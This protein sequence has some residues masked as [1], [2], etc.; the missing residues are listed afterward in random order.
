MK[1]IGKETNIQALRKI[2]SLFQTTSL[3]VDELLAMV[4][5]TAKD[6]V[7]VKNGSLLLVQDEKTF[8]LQFYQAFGKNMGQ[9]KDIDLPPGVGISGHV[10]KTGETI[11]SNDVAKDPR[12]YQGVSEKM[13]I[14]VQSMAS[15]PLII[16]KKVI[17]VVQFLDKVDGTT[18][19]EKNVETLQSFA[20]LMAKFFQVSKSRKLL[21]EEFGRLK[22]QYLLRYT[23]VGESKAIQKCIAMAEKV[24][25]SKAS[26][27]LTGESGTGKELF[28]H[29]VH[30]RSQRQNKPFVSVSCGA[31]PASILERELFG[32]EKGAFT[33]ADSQKI[34]LFEA[35]NT[36]T[37]FLDEIGEMPLDM[38]VKLL[39]VIQEES[40]IRLGGTE[41]IKVDV[42]LITATNLDLD[43]E[44]Q[45]G[46]FRQDLFYRINVI[47]ITLP[48]L[49]EKLEDI[50]D[51]LTFFIKKHSPENQP[52]KKPGKGLISHLMSY[53]WPGNIREL[54]NSVERSIVLTDDDELLPEAFP[55]ETSQAPIELNVGSTLKQASDLFRRTFISNTLKSTSGNRTK[56]AQI[57]DVQR[58]Y[59]S[60]LIKEL[61]IK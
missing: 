18:F 27:L 61:E 23:I 14:P 49:R 47:K 53:A 29:L 12:W 11:I 41:T 46:K 43:K 17:G 57:L 34:G 51:L 35:A 45:E 60:R 6:I 26:V 40:F 55:F 59:L 2:S 21:G 39:R 7:G 5:N 19:D 38:Q 16:D 28:A 32:H 52:I 50:P 37:L 58:S 10:A 54:E 4:M 25:D 36:G 3:E 13:R 42:R 33:G 8:K 20:N 56:A 1:R 30:D 48:P 9:L 24:A 44:V 15:F 22:E 31:L